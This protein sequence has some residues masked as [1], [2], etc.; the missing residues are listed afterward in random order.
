M[1]LQESKII[2]I[3]VAFL[4]S[5]SFIFAIIAENKKVFFNLIYYEELLKSEV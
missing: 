3:L 5:L 4:G 1:A 2:A